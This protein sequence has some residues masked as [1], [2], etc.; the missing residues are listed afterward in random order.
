MDRARRFGPTAVVLIGIFLAGCTR[1]IPPT[2]F[3][4][5]YTSNI[6]VPD[7]DLA[8]LPCRIFLGQ[9]GDGHCY[10]KDVIPFGQ[11]GGFLG[12]TILWRCPAAELPARFV[13]V[14]RPGDVILDGRASAP[15]TYMIQSFRAGGAVVE[16]SGGALPASQP[17]TRPAIPAA[18]QPA[19][20]E[21]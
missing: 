12:K 6:E 16:P 8:E 2:E 19:L 18:T 14:C 10:L 1:T 3:L 11:G 5:K 4:E 9:H 15:H 17:A 13:Q 7:R 21:D 20:P